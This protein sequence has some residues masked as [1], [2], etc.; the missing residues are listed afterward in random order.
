MCVIIKLP[1]KFDISFEKIKNATLN[2]PDGWGLVSIVN[3]DLVVER[4]CDTVNGNDPD[5][6]YGKL[7]EYRDSDRFLHVRKNTVGKTCIENTHP[8]TVYKGVNR[9]IEFMHNGTFHKFRPPV[10]SESS[11][12]RYFA[13]TYLSPLLYHFYGE[14]G[15]GDFSDPFFLSLVKDSFDY[16][17]RG[18]LISNDIGTLELGTWVDV[19]DGDN[20]FRASNN[21]YFTS[22]INTRVHSSKR[23]VTDK[24]NPTFQNGYYNTPTVVAKTNSEAKAP[25]ETTTI[26]P[27]KDVKLE[28][29]SGRFLK[30]ED[31]ES[32]FTVSSENFDDLDNDDIRAFAYLSSIEIYTWA[33]QNVQTASLIIELMSCRFNELLEEYEVVDE[34]RVKANEKHD[35]ASKYIE[36]LTL[37]VADLKAQV[38]M[39]TNE[40]DDLKAKAALLEKN[41]KTNRS[42]VPAV[43]DGNTSEK[44]A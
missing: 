24:G 13:E 37:Q 28:K 29:I 15:V 34:A 30:P 16:N 18:L 11:D 38:E 44:A 7:V 42:R 8:F 25:N 36:D 33:K 14:K 4:N 20:T 21:D 19:K 17:S 27:L 1:S 35:K 32:L 41:S 31:L 26:T 6:I 22:V 12:T 2:N 9:H 5:V 23:E 43:T 3:G 40:R 39:L 10:T